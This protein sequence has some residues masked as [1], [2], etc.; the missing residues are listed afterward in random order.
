MIPDI[1][2]SEL[3]ATVQILGLGNYFGV[4]DFVVG[5]VNVT[6]ISTCAQVNA[7]N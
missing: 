5:V 3:N 7:Q 6:N 2:H 4:R 1:A